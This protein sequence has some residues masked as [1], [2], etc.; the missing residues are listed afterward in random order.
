MTGI[1]SVLIAN[2]GEIAVRIL[3][4]V[5]KAGMKGI[6][7]HH[8]V[9]ADTPAVKRADVAIEITGPS[10]VAA[11]LDGTQIIAAAKAA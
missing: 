8:A 2:R 3:R 11:Y 10:P 4:S 1:S 6:V 7:V 5:R 9:D